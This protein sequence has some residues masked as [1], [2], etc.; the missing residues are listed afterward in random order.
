VTQIQ[1]Q[2]VHHGVDAAIACRNPAIHIGLAKG[3]VQLDGKAQK[4][5]PGMDCYAG[6]R[7]GAAALQLMS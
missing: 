1:H 4:R 2:Q 7:T 6:M 5:C 3:K